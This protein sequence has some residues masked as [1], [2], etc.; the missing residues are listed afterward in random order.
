[1]ESNFDFNKIGKR[2]PYTTPDSF[3]DSLE[4]DILKR[5]KTKSHKSVIITLS[6]L[7]AAACIASVVLLSDIF[8]KPQVGI[9]NVDTAFASLSEQDQDFLLDVYSDDVFINNEV[10]N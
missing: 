10:S 5:S 3:F 8:D 2:M 6:S 9:E 4:T 1:M 7:A